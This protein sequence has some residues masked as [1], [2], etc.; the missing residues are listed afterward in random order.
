MLLPQ[1]P[2]DEASAIGVTLR[3]AVVSDEPFLWLMLFHAAHMA[4]DGARSPDE[5]REHPFLAKFVRAW[6]RPGDLGVIA[7][8][9]P[10]GRPLGA[11]WLR[12]L[13]GAE[14]SYPAVD[15]AYPELAIAVLPERTGS[16]I[17]GALLGRLLDL[18]HPHYPGIVLSVRA[19]N[20]ACRLYERHGFVVSDEI[21]NRVGTH[22]YVME[23]RL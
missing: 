19:D 12:H 8:D 5:A 18:A 15:D 22:S 17:G 1:Q 16:G 23:R 10:D 9:R 20:P 7:E 6:G 3:E 4:A 2:S 11:A 21:V 13:T 14:K